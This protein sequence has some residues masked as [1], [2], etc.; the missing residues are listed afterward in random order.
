VAY[1]NSE[2]VTD[3]KVVSKIERGAKHADM[4]ENK[5]GKYKVGENRCSV[6]WGYNEVRGDHVNPRSNNSVLS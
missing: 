6:K 5:R 4:V 3:R 1:I 2:L